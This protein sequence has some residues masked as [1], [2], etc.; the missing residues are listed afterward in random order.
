MANTQ[1]IEAIADALP[2]EQREAYLRVMTRLREVPEDDEYLLILEA[3]GFSSL[4]LREIP[5]QVKEVLAAADTVD[6]NASS[7]YLLRQIRE[8]LREAIQIPSYHDLKKQLDRLSQVR[9]G[10]YEDIRAL[11]SKLKELP[12]KQSDGSTWVFGFVT[13]VF[14]TAAILCS[15]GI[16]AWFQ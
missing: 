6:S 16:R 1:A 7:E 9:A 13:G 5:Q 12:S 11:S 2:L 3:I 10:L 4:I 15:F 14:V 8:E